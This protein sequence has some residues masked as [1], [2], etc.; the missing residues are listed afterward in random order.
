MFTKL[1]TNVHKSSQASPVFQ[2]GSLRNLSGQSCGYGLYGDGSKVLFFLWTIFVHKIWL[3]LFCLFPEML[4]I[5]S[6]LRLYKLAH[7]R[8][9]KTGPVSSS[10]CL[11][12]QILY[13]TFFNFNF[14]GLKTAFKMHA[15]S[16]LRLWTFVNNLWTFVN[17]YFRIENMTGRAWKPS[18][19][20]LTTRQLIT[21]NLSDIDAEFDKE[22]EAFTKCSQVRLEKREFDSQ[23]NG[24]HCA[25]SSCSL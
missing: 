7:W 14:K 17:I 23:T 1:F 11:G 12:P 8:P 10:T 4:K 18:D 22:V 6:G 20:L 25:T 19:K 16:N 24:E 13:V 2:D 3:W 5:R 9:R 15:S 21:D